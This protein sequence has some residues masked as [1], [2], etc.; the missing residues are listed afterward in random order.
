M[1]HLDFEF[2]V[3]VLVVHCFHKKNFVGQ[4]FTSDY[5]DKLES[6]SEMF[7]KMTMDALLLQICG[8]LTIIEERYTLIPEKGKDKQAKSVERIRQDPEII[9]KMVKIFTR[10]LDGKQVPEILVSSSRK[11]KP[12]TMIAPFTATISKT[13][14]NYVGKQHSL[15]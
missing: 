5:H 11:M 4:Y 8:A 12:S 7:N 13:G 15:I 2:S 14:K 9:G 1:Y 10:T 6:A 3:F